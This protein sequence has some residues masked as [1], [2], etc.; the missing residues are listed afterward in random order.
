MSVWKAAGCE[1]FVAKQPTLL[2]EILDEMVC[3]TA[4]IQYS[5]SCQMSRLNMIPNHRRSLTFAI[6]LDVL[7]GPSLHSPHDFDVIS[8]CDFCF[9]CGFY[10]DVFC[11]A[12][13]N[14]WSGYVGVAK[15]GSESDFGFYHHRLRSRLSSMMI[16]L[17]H[18]PSVLLALA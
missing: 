7:L 9:H 10:G 8:L 15:N 1:E 16:P 14:L 4:S 2:P 6:A 11:C 12:P 13:H 5:S 18:R 17:R 3:S